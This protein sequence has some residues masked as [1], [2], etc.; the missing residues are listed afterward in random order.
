VSMLVRRVLGVVKNQRG[1]TTMLFCLLIL[2][3]LVTIWLFGLVNIQTTTASDA[4]V[5]NALEIAARSAAS[6]IVPESMAAGNP[7]INAEQANTVFKQMLAAN[8]GLDP[9]TLNPLPGSMIKRP[10]YSLAVYNIDGTYAGSGAPA[11][12]IY[13]FSG[14]TLNTQNYYPS[15]TSF[16]FGVRPANIR[17]GSSGDIECTLKYPGV[18]ASIKADMQN[19]AGT[20]T[21]T[22]NRWVAAKIVVQ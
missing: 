17:P 15:G 14:G 13:T 1:D 9:V 7:R 22:I 5:L 4:S 6:Q 18:V 10:D 3:L 2:F 21:V 12:K 8:L 16:L 20:Q 19:I 11:G